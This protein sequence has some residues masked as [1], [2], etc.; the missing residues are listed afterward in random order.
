MVVIEDLQ[1]LCAENKKILEVI[2]SL[3]TRVEY[4]CEMLS[5]LLDEEHEANTKNTEIEESSP[6]KKKEK[7]SDKLKKISKADTKAIDKIKDKLNEEGNN[8]V[9]VEL[10]KIDKKSYYVDKNGVVYDKK[11]KVIGEY[12]F[13]EETI[14]LE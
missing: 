13:E 4:N 2:E 3:K 12:D 7:K 5:N 10:I 9:E 6:K 8:E 1:Y 14:I 11:A